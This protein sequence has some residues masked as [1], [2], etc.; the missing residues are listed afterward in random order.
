MRFPTTHWSEVARAANAGEGVKRAAL[1]KLLL[2]YLPALRAYLL[3]SWGQKREDVDDLLQGF[4]CDRVVADGLIAQV[5]A[6]R[7]RFRTFLLAALDNY[8]LHVR[9]QEQALKRRPKQGFL[10]MSGAEPPA[11]APRRAPADAFEVAWSRQVIADA[12]ERMRVQ[13]ARDPRREKVWQ[14]F[15]ARVLAPLRGDSPAPSFESLRATFG[16]ESAAQASNL[17]VTGKR[18]FARALW[19]VIGE[20]AGDEAEIEAEIR[21]L[22]SVIVRAGRAVD[23]LQNGSE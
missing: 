18:A 1:G 21:D 14:V 6:T 19:S 20:Y 8:A 4:V 22:W 3:R 11:P 9:R 13:Y 23:V 2:R 7:G 15:E 16:L 5:R 12:L 10:L 17:V